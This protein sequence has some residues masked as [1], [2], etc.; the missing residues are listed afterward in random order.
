MYE[1]MG[2]VKIADEEEEKGEARGCNN[3]CKKGR[4]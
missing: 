3:G 4:N 2:Y 1:N